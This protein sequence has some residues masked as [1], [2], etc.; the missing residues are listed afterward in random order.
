V[1]LLGT[2]PGAGVARRPVGRWGLTGLLAV[3]VLWSL[4]GTGVGPASLAAADAAGAQVL[5]GMLRP[6]L[7]PEVLADVGRAALQTVQVAVAGLVLSVLLAVPVALLLTAHARVARPL[8]E[9][10]RTV[11]GLLRG[12]PELVW[13]LLLVATVGLG[14]TAG[15]YALGLHGAGLLGKLW[16]EQLD[17]VDPVPVEAV[18]LAGAGR[19][20]VLALAVVPQA[21]AGLGSLLLYQLECNV[22]AATVL[23]VVGAG[24][25]G[26]Q[27]D[28]ALRL[29]DHR[30]LGTLVLAVLVLV[31]GVDALSRAVRRRFG[32]RWAP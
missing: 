8:R 31:L 29:F 26:G 21:G 15:A 7:R 20:A 19:A 3:V 5:S 13:A 23:G 2:P 27:I 6:D 10:A 12:V 22:R 32:A 18:R 24:G 25:L 28:L 9:A 30:Q 14:P 1:T 16:A 11:A 17:A 4:H